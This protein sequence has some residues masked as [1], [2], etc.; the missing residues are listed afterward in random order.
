MHMLMACYYNIADGRVD[1]KIIYR[2]NS[3]EMLTGDHFYVADTADE[4][5]DLH[6]K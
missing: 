2:I 6:A 4:N 1:A 3:R 5:Q